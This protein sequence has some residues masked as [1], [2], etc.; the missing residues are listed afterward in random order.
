MTQVSTPLGDARENVRQAMQQASPFVEAYARVG[1]AAKG[2]VYVLVGLLAGMAA[3]GARRATG[4]K[5]A[6]A[7]LMHKPFGRVML[8]AV[9]LGILGYCV[10]QFIRAIEDPER[11]GSDPKGIGKRFSYF[12]SGVV[13]FGLVLAAAE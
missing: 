4:S 12:F 9:A 13:H 7:E 11:E 8:G 1:Y 3:I 6:M 5:G 10:W 2:V